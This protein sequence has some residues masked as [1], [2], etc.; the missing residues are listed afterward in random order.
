[1]RLVSFVSLLAAAACSASAV[2]A[3]ATQE[4][5]VHLPAEPLRIDT[6]HGYREY[7]VEVARTGEQRERGLMFRTSLPKH[8]GM[9][10]PMS[11]PRPA[12]FWMKNTLIPLDLVFIRADGTIARIAADC[13]PY[14][15]ALIESGEPVAAVLELAG[16]QATRD[17]I[18]EG[19]RVVTAALNLKP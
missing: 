5:V 15:L 17:G 16:G 14:S 3:R 13:T 9:I 18:K 10:F 1:M 7:R 4:Q 2:S 8:G 12:S 19:D 11:P 6:S